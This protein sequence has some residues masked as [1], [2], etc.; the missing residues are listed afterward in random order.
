MSKN[1]IAVITGGSS[2]IGKAISDN[3]LKQEYI[4]VNADIRAPEDEGPED[5]VPCDVTLSK[6][7]D[8]L[9]HHVISKYGIPD[10]LISNAGQGIHEKISEGDPEKWARVIDINLMGS[11]RFVRTFLPDMLQRKQGDIVFI[12]STAGNQVFAYGGIY[13]ATKAAL[14]MVARTLRLEV[15]GILRVC[16]VC[17]GVVDTSFFRN[18]IGSDHGVEDIGWGS[19]SAGQV[20]DIV[21]MIVHFPGSLHIPEITL[22]PP[23]Q[24]L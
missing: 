6:D 2:G 23:K 20:A 21:S 14:N 3:F 10:V 11:L 7:V 22:C 5:Y 13:T 15:E 18:M 17:P 24:Q 16:L 12:S 8:E 19:L 9:Y 4:V 1:K